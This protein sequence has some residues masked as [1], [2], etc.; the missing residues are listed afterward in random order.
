MPP[1]WQDPDA[2][3][4]MNYPQKATPDLEL[5]RILVIDDEAAN[6]EALDKILRWA[7]YPW[8]LTTTDPT[9]AARL[10]SEI[11][12]DLIVLDLHM[13]EKD[14]FDV[15]AELAEMTDR[16]EYLPILVLTGDMDPVARERALSAGAK[17]FVTKPFETTEVLL[18]IK[19]LLETRSLHT[20]LHRHAEELEDKIAA[21]T[22]DLADAQLEILSRLALAAE[23]R[24]DV[25]GQHA[26]RV[27]AL[28]AL[29]AEEVGLSAEDVELVRWAAPLH[30]IGKIGI[31]DAIL[32]K[33]GKLLDA[34]Y[35]V[36]KSHTTIGARILSGSRFPI[37]QMARKIALS[38]HERWD[39][40]GYTGLV[41]EEIPIEG[42]IVAVAD[43]FDCLT[44]ERPYKAAMPVDQTVELIDSE[45]G[46]HFD[47]RV[48][49]AFLRLIESGRILEIGILLARKAS[50]GTVA[51][52]D[53]VHLLDLR[54]A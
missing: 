19:N 29:I 47:P 43:T 24:D 31:P 53:S 33:P 40:R 14:G 9:E 25:T 12:P 26:E 50:D 44:N 23:Y 30:D 49:D 22:R 16:E 20:R 21:R 34:E 6:V 46:R 39:G 3:R 13:P 18:R 8:V 17:D 38:H 28:S 5:S 32:L 10:Y 36:M 45:R 1:L 27:G 42:R 52:Q 48:V 7:G 54:Y 4:T 15:M 35:E 37:M 51:E 11:R 2:A 41:G